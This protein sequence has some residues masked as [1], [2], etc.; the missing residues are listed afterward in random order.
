MGA[1]SA[2]I[3][4]LG[5]AQH[6]EEGASPRW[7]VGGTETLAWF[8]SQEGLPNQGCIP[9]PGMAS[10]HLIAVMGLPSHV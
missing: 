4:V 5:A 1:P 10:V 8:A 6:G 7:A 3:P 9:E 2:I